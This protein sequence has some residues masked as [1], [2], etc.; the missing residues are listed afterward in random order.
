MSAAVEETNK[1]GQ[2]RKPMLF[3]F[4]LRDGLRLVSH[5]LSGGV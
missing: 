5:V 4:S 2:N 3:M 1:N